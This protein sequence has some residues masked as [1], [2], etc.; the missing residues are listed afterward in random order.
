MKVPPGPIV[1]DASVAIALVRSEVTSRR[2]R[3]LIDT[4]TLSGTELVAPSLLWL[5][6]ANALVPRS[7]SPSATLEALHVIERLGVRT[8]HLERPLLVLAVG[9]AHVHGLTP[10]DAV[11]LALAESEDGRLAT[12]DRALA[13]A[14]GDR[15]ILLTDDS[16]GVHERP[17]TY[18]TPPRSSSEPDPDAWPGFDRY[19]ARLRDEADVPPSR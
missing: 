6:V 7:P 12:T 16:T 1:L 19:V 3:Q 17:A 18:G 5:E 14:A 15:A 13:V 10:Y 11:Y 2:A 9:H 8:V 4:W